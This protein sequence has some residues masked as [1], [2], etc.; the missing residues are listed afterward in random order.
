MGIK[1]ALHRGLLMNLINSNSLHHDHDH[2]LND[3]Q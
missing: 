2:D 3:L 1:K